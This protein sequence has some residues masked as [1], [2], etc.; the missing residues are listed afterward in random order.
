MYESTIELLGEY[1]Q[2][3]VRDGVPEFSRNLASE[4][5]DRL[6]QLDYLQC[7]VQDLCEQSENAQSRQKATMKAHINNKTNK[8]L[9]WEQR[10]APPELKYSDEELKVLIQA[11]FEIQLF[12][13][14]FYYLAG[15]IRTIIKSKAMP[16]LKGFE[17]VGVRNV[18]NKLL[19][20]SHE[21][22]S[23]VTTVSFAYGGTQGPVL[24][25]SRIQGQESVFPDRG[26]YVN[27]DE[28]IAN[29]ET[30][31]RKAINGPALLP[32]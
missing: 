20:H 12:A 13:E 15:R 23:K 5:R 17:C 22:D 14:C 32:D 26:L 21:H 1:Y 24:K 27:A 10:P 31:L 16:G 25:A 18:R 30:E 9:L 4:V 29:L 7:K 28:F 19:E 3:M 2:K 8:G 11:S 6:K